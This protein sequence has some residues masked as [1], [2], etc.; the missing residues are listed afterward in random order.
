MDRELICA[1]EAKK[2]HDS[3]LLQIEDAT[4]R[5]LMIEEIDSGSKAKYK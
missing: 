4:P 2:V 3:S 5:D 1:E